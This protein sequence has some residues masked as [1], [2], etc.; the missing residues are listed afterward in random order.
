MVKNYLITLTLKNKSLDEIESYKMLGKNFLNS[1]RNFCK[2][3]KVNYA[4]YFSFSTSK[5]KNGIRRN[6]R[7]HFHL[8]LKTNKINK[9]KKFITKYWKYGFVH[10][11]N[12]SHCLFETMGYTIAQEEWAFIQGNDCAY[13]MEILSIIENNYNSSEK[14]IASVVET[15]KGEK[16]E[17]K[18]NN[19]RDT[20]NIYDPRVFYDV[21]IVYGILVPHRKWYYDT[22]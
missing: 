12:V 4:I 2:K 7:L 15:Q 20:S 1:L 3:K 11:K 21:V 13:K 19:I 18:I 10:F 14:E 9:I 6:S 16:L 8:I 17:F 22:S 5:I